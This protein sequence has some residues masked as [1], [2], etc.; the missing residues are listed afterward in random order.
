MKKIHILLLLLL[1]VAMT[2]NS[3]GASKKSKAAT[4]DTCPAE[5][6][7][8]YKKLTLDL[9]KILGYAEGYQVVNNG[10]IQR[11]Q[12]YNPKISDEFVEKLNKD[13][14]N[15]DFLESIV[16][17]YSQYFSLN[18]VKALHKYF[19]SNTFHKA[20]KYGVKVQN[21]IDDML[22][23][24]HKRRTEEIKEQIKNAGYEM[25]QFLMLDEDTNSVINNN[26]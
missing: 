1:S 7:A 9:M 3:E 21:E 18:D 25:P 24:Y 4:G 8:E 12:M 16:K 23:I 13:I 20:N 10:I 5:I 15:S 11:L 22:G 17:I 14:D 6:T 19:T 26:N 2:F